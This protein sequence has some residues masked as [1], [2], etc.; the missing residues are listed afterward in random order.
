MTIF[1]QFYHFQPPHNGFMQG[2]WFL[3]VMVMSQTKN[4]STNASNETYL[5]YLQPKADNKSVFVL[6]KRMRVWNVPSNWHKNLI[7]KLLQAC[8]WDVACCCGCQIH[9]KQPIITAKSVSRS[10]QIN[11]LHQSSTNS[12]CSRLI[13]ER[14]V[15]EGGHIYVTLN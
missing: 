6:R 14:G 3:W 8:N 10:F 5:V 1:A 15:R 7:M 9:C 12:K 13:N 2:L 11:C 4:K